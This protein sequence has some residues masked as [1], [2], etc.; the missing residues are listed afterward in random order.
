MSTEIQ[1]KVYAS[2]VVALSSEYR[3]TITESGTYPVLIIKDIGTT[4]TYALYS[5]VAQT[6]KDLLLVTD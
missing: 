3:R 6:T 5:S 2:D 4:T 1:E